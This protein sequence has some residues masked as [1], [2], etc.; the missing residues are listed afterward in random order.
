MVEIDTERGTD[1]AQEPVP[2]KYPTPSTIELGG[3]TYV[4]EWVPIDQLGAYRA[5][6]NLVR[7]G[8][9]FLGKPGWRPTH[10]GKMQFSGLGTAII[11]W[12]RS[13]VEELG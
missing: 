4:L 10:D 8:N 9:A 11:H 3:T 13:W 5:K 7:V 2:L 1:P 6:H 12:P